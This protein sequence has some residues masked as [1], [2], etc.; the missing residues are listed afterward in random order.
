MTHFR[1]AMW[2]LF[3][4]FKLKGIRRRDLLRL[5][6]KS[7]SLYSA[8]LAFTDSH[9]PSDQLQRTMI[10]GLFS[11]VYDYDTDWIGGDA[12]GRNLKHLL[13]TYVESEEIQL[14]VTA[15]FE[16]DKADELTDHGL[17]RGSVALSFFRSVISSDWMQ[18]YTD[19]EIKL[20]GWKLQIIDDILDLKED[21]ERGH[22][23]CLLLDNPESF[24]AEAREFLISEFF[25]KLR[26]N[27]VVYSYIAWKCNRILDRLSTDP[28]SFKQLFDTSRP[29]TGVFAVV[30]TVISFRYLETVDWNVTVLTAVGYAGITWSIMSFNDWVDRKHDLKK[31]KRFAYEHSRELLQY[32]LVLALAILVILGLLALYNPLLAVY[33]F[34]VWGIGLAYSYV[35]H[36]Y[37]VQNVVVGLCSASPVLSSSVYS[38]DMQMNAFLLFFTF[39]SIIVMREIH[40]D[41]EDADIDKGYKATLPVRIGQPHST[42][43]T[44]NLSLFATVGLILYPNWWVAAIAVLFGLLQFWNVRT[45]FSP[46]RAGSSKKVL[47]LIVRVIFVVVLFVQ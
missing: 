31:E 44:F 25:G 20:F 22:K 12:K 47:D 7:C 28:V 5:W 9:R 3:V 36:W 24:I 35:P 26:S 33:C 18:D 13:C 14:L 19:G 32:T 2:A 6:I 39:V 27:S 23:N 42:L 17:E 38:G 1:L 40:K 29:M 46:S 16:E 34:G 43:A 41:M 10:C 11:A 21:R 45:F 37:R 15:L 4:L 30:L 8:M